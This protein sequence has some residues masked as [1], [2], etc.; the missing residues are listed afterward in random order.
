V[1]DGRDPRPPRV[2]HDADRAGERGPFEPPPFQPRELDEREHQPG[3]GR[4]PE[5][6]RREAGD[7]G[8]VAGLGNGAGPGGWS[9]G[10]TQ[11][12]WSPDLVRELDGGVTTS[13]ALDAH[14]NG[15]SSILLSMEVG[16]SPSSPPP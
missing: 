12:K 13:L 7:G 10:N 15:L 2:G 9:G 5:P 16:V 4:H 1:P 11:K 8:D 6:G 14:G 3:D